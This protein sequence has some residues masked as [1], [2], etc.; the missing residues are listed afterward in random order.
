MCHYQDIRLASQKYFATIL[1]VQVMTLEE[2]MT[3]LDACQKLIAEA[4]IPFL[5]WDKLQVLIKRSCPLTAAGPDG[6]KYVV[7]KFPI[8]FELCHDTSLA[9]KRATSARREHQRQGR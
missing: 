7:F 6:I 4:G 5:E 3:D 1:D 9:T 2:V 8:G